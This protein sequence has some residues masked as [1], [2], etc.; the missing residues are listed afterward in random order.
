MSYIT[1]CLEKFSTLPEEIQEAVGNLEVLQKITLLEQKHNV[2]LGF[3]VILVTIGELMMEDIEEYLQKKYKLDQVVA[4]N[5]NS[6]LQEQIFKPALAKV[7]PE[8]KVV[9]TI[10]IEQEKKIIVD[11]FATDLISVLLGNADLKKAV[12]LRIFYILNKDLNFRKDLERAFYDNQQKLTRKAF[13][14]QNQNMPPTIGNWF[15]DFIKKKGGAMPDNLAIADY[16]ANSE[17]AIKLNS[18]EKK[19]LRN[20]IVTYR[21]I[22]FFPTSMPNDTGEGWEIVPLFKKEADI[23]TKGTSISTPVVRTT[24]P[25]ERLIRQAQTAKGGSIPVKKTQSLTKE[26]VNVLAMKLVSQVDAVSSL[27]IDLINR[28]KNIIDSYLRDIRGTDATQEILQRSTKKGG[29]GLSLEDSVNVMNIVSQDYQ[30]IHFPSVAVQTPEIMTDQKIREKKE[31]LV[32]IPK[33]VEPKK[34]IDEQTM[35]GERDRKI[36]KDITDSKTKEVVTQDF[37]VVA[38]SKEP[39]VD[40]QLSKKVTVDHLEISKMQEVLSGSSQEIKKIKQLES[41]IKNSDDDKIEKIVTNLQRSISYKQ[42][43]EVLVRLKLLVQQGNLQQL[44]PLIK[45]KTTDFNLENFQK[46]IQALFSQQMGL[47]DADTA[48]YGM[49]LAMDLKKQGKPEFIKAVYFD[50]NENIFKWKS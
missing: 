32:Q 13:S 45:Q 19:L 5:I 44:L 38:S 46:L 20:L 28:L 42:P 21:N 18:S 41:K 27:R 31:E 8:E 33:D 36:V 50:E 26:D 15:K 17:N 40:K 9:P 16:V 47:T 6:D 29:L 14:I 22:K 48:R 11:I 25:V 10:D 7:A 1:E 24:D 34:I 3:L 4:R 35:K 12:N 37:K 2:E 39:L 43:E 49:Q 23:G 30:N